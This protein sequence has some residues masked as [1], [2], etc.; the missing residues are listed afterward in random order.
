MKTKISNKALLLITILLSVG[1]YQL[2]ATNDLT[3]KNCLQGNYGLSSNTKMYFFG[4]NVG[5]PMV[6]NEILIN[7]C[8]VYFGMVS[9]VG[10]YVKGKSNFNF[11]SG[12]S[13]SLE[14]N[15]DFR[16]ITD[17]KWQRYGAVLGIFMRTVEPVYLY[18]GV[19]YG[20]R[21]QLINV[22]CYNNSTGIYNKK[23]YFNRYNS[24]ELEAGLTVKV[25]MFT[26]SFG[27]AMLPIGNKQPYFE[28]SGGVGMALNKTN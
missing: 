18:F 15:S 3:L 6:K 20:S 9:K 16:E 24:I 21:K 23:Y 17:T 11:S 8:E 5:F 1:S 12:Y 22:S 26:V 10:F 28:L 19:G 14:F 27:G 4:Y 7:P 25:A 13:T 2:N